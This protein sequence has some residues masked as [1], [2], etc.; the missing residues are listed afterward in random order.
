MYA[1]AHQDTTIYVI[2]VRGKMFSRRLRAVLGIRN[3]ERG[4]NL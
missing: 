4:R 3:V 1:E 2:G